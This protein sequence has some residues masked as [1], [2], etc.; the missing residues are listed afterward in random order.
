[1]IINEKCLNEFSDINLP[2]IISTPDAQKFNLFTSCS[3]HARTRHL[4]QFN[5]YSK[6]GYSNKTVSDVLSWLKIAVPVYLRES[7]KNVTL[8]FFFITEVFLLFV[9]N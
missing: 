3:S 5:Q 8:I 4:N 2:P 9:F 6:A 1:M 7:F